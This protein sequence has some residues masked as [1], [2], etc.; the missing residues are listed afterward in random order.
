[1]LRLWPSSL[2]VVREAVTTQRAKVAAVSQVSGLL[3]L[4]CSFAQFASTTVFTANKDLRMLFLSLSLGC[5][6]LCFYHVLGL[7]GATSVIGLQPSALV[8]LRLHLCHSMAGS[9][10]SPDM[11][12]HEFSFHWP[13]CYKGAKDSYFRQIIARYNIAKDFLFEMS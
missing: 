9:G 12:P 7:S 11:M 13:R 2:W 6:P 10:L 4:T 3:A 5:L 1:M 8:G